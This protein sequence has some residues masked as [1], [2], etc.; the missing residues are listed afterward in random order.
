MPVK[1]FDLPVTGE[2]KIRVV[3]QQ[4]DV[5]VFAETPL[6][7]MLHDFPG[8]HKSS[9]D[10]LFDDMEYRMAAMGLPSVRFDF[11]GCG[12]S[13][14]TEVEFCLENAV[15]DLNAVLQWAQH[16]A[17][18]RSCIMVGEG[19]GA[20]V[21]ALGYKTETVRAMILLWPALILNQTHFKGLFTREK[22]L[23]GDKSEDGHVEFNGHRLGKLFIN[24]I[25][26]SDLTATLQKIKAPTLIQHGT[27]DGDVPLNQAY[28]G[29]DHIPGMA[30]L[31]IFEG[32]VHGLKGLNIRQ[33]MFLNIEYFL[34]RLLKKL[35]LSSKN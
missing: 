23:E 20:T 27:A 22:M 25:Y 30:D 19:M 28:F 13:D 9:C 34:G 8:G 21:A 31:A 33:H 12:E 2:Q 26:Q 24:E 15:A 1:S 7:V 3:Y 4:P 14:S 29:R 32:G 11:R 6:I 10:G 35:D 18:H 16:D 5:S 17:G